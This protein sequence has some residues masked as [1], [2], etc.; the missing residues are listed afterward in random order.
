LLREAARQRRPEVVQA[1]AQTR[2]AQA[3]VS[4]A[5]IGRKPRL[6][7][8]FAFNI[9]PN[10][11]FNR[12]D[13]A[14]AAAMFL[15]TSGRAFQHLPPLVLVIAFAGL[16]FLLWMENGNSLLIV[17]GDLKRLNF[18][19]AAGTTTGILLVSVMVGVLKGGVLAALSATLISYFVVIGLGLQRVIAASRPLAVSRA[20]LRQLV[21]GGVRLHLSAV[22]TFFF[23]NIA[24]I[25]LNNFR[26][27][28][29]AGYFQF[30]MQM[31]LAMQVVPMAIAIVAYTI[32]TRDGADGAW[33]EHRTLILQTL[34]YSAAAAVIALPL[35]V[36]YFLAQK[37][38][39]EGI[40]FSGLKG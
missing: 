16:P 6:D 11:A 3:S 26:P 9:S 39:V 1:E 32:V 15:I 28:A 8:Q 5:R 13:W 20:V 7:T 40:T 27:V 10:N 2:A 19:Q 25:L 14:I 21:G 38:F 24:V 4:I 37:K 29:E 35:V 33:R 30:A 22:S 17:L 36:I 34:L 31:I 18:A 12:S 23:T